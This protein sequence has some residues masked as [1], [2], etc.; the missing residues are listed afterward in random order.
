MTIK[1]NKEAPTVPGAYWIKTSQRIGV[2]RHLLERTFI[3][4]VKYEEP[5]DSDEEEEQLHVYSE[6]TMDHDGFPELL[7]NLAER[8]SSAIEWAGPLEGPPE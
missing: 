7:C 5:I 2:P 3:C 6:H 8:L 4:E 1:W